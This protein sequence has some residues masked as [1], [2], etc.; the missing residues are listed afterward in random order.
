M[1]RRTW[2]NGAAFA[3]AAIALPGC[4]LADDTPTYRY[5]LTVEVNTPEGVRNGSSVI[6]VTTHVA[7]Q[8]AFPD[9]GQVSHRARGEAVAVDLPGGRTL[10]ALLRSEDEVDWPGMVMFLL[11]PDSAKIG[12]EGFLERYDAML[13]NHSVIE[14]PATFPDVGHIRN[15]SAYPMLVTFGDLADP[16]SVALV[17]PDD[18]AASLGPGVA[19]RR[20]TVQMTDDP[21]TTGIQQRLEWI[22]HIQ[23]MDLSLQ[24][25][26]PDFPVGDFSGLFKKE[27]F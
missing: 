23:E 11:A 9:R 2:I 1:K 18:L 22:G 16:A 25:F 24:D 27:D 19:L 15:R 10:F 3:V 20:I 14:L 7:S 12:T 4:A 26:P 6:E 13:A 21:V 5:R 8:N 17:D